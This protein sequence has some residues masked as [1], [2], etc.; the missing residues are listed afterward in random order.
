V[1]RIA[2][3]LLRFSFGSTFF[4]FGAVARTT[5]CCQGGR[6]FSP[7]AHHF[8]WLCSALPARRRFA[9]RHPSRTRHIMRTTQARALVQQ[10]FISHFTPPLLTISL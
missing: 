3:Q 5:V 1:L 7:P 6:R 8:F 9:P 4:C 2:A 10:C